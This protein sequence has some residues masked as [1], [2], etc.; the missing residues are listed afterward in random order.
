MMKDIRDIAINPLD[1]A[2][3]ESKERQNRKATE[4]LINNLFTELRAICTAWRQAWPD[5]KTYDLARDHWVG[6]FMDA[7]IKDI[8]QIEFGLRKQRLVGKSFIPSIGE[9]IALC[10]PTAKDFS[11]PD[12]DSAY[13]QAAHLAYPRADM[14]GICDAV[15]HAACMTGFYEINNLPR[16]KSYPMFVRNYQLTIDMVMSGQALREVP[17]MLE[18]QKPK[19]K[20]EESK[21][22][23]KNALN[24]IKGMIK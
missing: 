20:T 2:E 13:R 19:E 7:G 11:L 12:V 14:A 24:K 23:A 22:A 15:Y 8:K 17:K 4:L 21:L 5:Q 10:R 9:F 18:H 16:D 6:G 3:P 1:H